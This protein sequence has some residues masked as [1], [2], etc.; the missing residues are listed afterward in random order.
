MLDKKDKGQKGQA[1]RTRCLGIRYELGTIR[2]MC[3]G[4]PVK[5]PVKNPVL[6]ND[7][8]RICVA[9]FR[10]HEINN[11]DHEYMHSN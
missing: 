11:T 5:Y 6:P 4:H 10:V 3:T 1:E 9:A 8:W 7:M 2:Y